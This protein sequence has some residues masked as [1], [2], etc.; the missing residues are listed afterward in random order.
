MFGFL[1]DVYVHPDHRGQGVGKYMIQSIMEDETLQGLRHI[2]LGTLDAHCLYQKVGFSTLEHPS[3]FMET[4]RGT[5]LEDM[6]M[7]R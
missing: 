2:M 3:V 5:K 1:S 4:Y 6:E 7:K